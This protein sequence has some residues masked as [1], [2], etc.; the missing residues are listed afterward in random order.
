MV[1]ERFKEETKIKIV[2]DEGKGLGYARDIGWRATSDNIKYVAMVDSD[3]M[4]DK[5]FFHDALQI[6]EK[7]DKLGALGAKLKPACNEKGVLAKFQMKNL[8]IHLHWQE[9]PYSSGVVAT[10]TACTIFRK[11]AL[12]KV[13][14][15]DPYFRIAKEDSDIGFRLSYLNHFATHLETGKRVWKINFR[16]GRSYVLISRKHPVEGRLWTK[17][18][19]M[20]TISLIL[21]PMKLVIWAYYFS[22]YLKLKDVSL[23]EVLVLSLVE[24]ARQAVRTLG[25]LY[26]VIFCKEG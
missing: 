6:L 19:I 9:A 5:S 1:V 7:D 17:K 22:R 8:A 14:G 11:S 15:F 13:N 18:N 25:M 21:F 26:E 23:R 24:T 20:L 10:H 2:F 4:V 12:E 3:V 16:Y